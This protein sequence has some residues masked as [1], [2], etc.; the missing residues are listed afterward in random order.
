MLLKFNEKVKCY[1]HTHVPPPP[2]Y[3]LLQ[4][5]RTLATVEFQKRVYFYFKHQLSVEQEK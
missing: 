3:I 5:A 4:T 2:I 1:L